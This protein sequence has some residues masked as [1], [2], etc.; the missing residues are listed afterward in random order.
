MA[1]AIRGEGNI[2]AGIKNRNFRPN[3]KLSSA[4]KAELKKAPCRCKM[5]TT[6]TGKRMR[7]CFK[8]KV[9]GGG[10]YVRRCKR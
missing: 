9:I 4:G 8:H 10:N 1:D 5:I 2:M 3:R 6:K 7:M